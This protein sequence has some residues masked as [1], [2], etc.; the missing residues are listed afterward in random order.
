MIQ[1]IQDHLTTMTMT[2]ISPSISLKLACVSQLGWHMGMVW[3]GEVQPAPVPTKPAPI[4]V[5]VQTHTAHP[6]VL[7]NHCGYL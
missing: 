2:P 7:S 1:Q 5:W 3:V 6:W 4:Q